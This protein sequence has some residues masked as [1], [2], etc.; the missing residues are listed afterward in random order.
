[1][2]LALPLVVD[3]VIF[4]GLLKGVVRKSLAFLLRQERC[5]RLSSMEAAAF[6]LALLG[7]IAGMLYRS[8]DGGRQ[9]L[10]VANPGTS[11]SNGGGE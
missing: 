11:K 1:V 4:E 2:V 6:E 3:G 9:L 8:T 5:L 10:E 7:A